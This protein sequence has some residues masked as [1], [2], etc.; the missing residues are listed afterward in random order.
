MTD[1]KFDPSM[2]EMVQYEK[3]LKDDTFEMEPI[4][5]FKDAWIRLRKNKASIVSMYII[6][7]ISFLS[8][9]GPSLNKYGFNDQNVNKINFPPR[10]ETFAKIGFWDGGR[11]LENRAVANLDDIER[12]PLGSVLE[13]KNVRTFKGVETLTMQLGQPRP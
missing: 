9:F 7:L 4:S 12:Y 10:V 6:L 3:D 2:F 13:V 1:R 11:L 5:Y 8:I